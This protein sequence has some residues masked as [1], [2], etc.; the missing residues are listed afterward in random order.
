M[1]HFKTHKFNLMWGR[2][3]KFPSLVSHQEEAHRSFPVLPG[4]RRIDASEEGDQLRPDS[5][6]TEGWIDFG[7]EVAF[8]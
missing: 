6:K 1:G 5:E 2:N 4:L 7:S 8:R 3:V